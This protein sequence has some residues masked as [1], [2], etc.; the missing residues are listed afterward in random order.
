MDINFNIYKVE[1]TKCIYVQLEDKLHMITA[2]E[3]SK[4]KS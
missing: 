4:E 1:D 2:I 3:Y